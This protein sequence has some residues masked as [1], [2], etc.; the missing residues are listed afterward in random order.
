MAMDVLILN[1][2]EWVLA[3][4]LAAEPWHV[5]I[6]HQRSERRNELHVWLPRA[7]RGRAGEYAFRRYW[8]EGTIRWCVEA[9]RDPD[10]VRGPSVAR[11][12]VLTLRFAAPTG[13]V[14]WSE[15][16]G[17]HRLADLT[18]ADLSRLRAAGT[19]GPF[20]KI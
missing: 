19:V 11:A 7:G 2:G 4:E 5:L 3:S 14:L 16:H 6:Y 20:S 9:P 13:L 18:D 1:S 10:R 17:G 12:S 15:Y 8:L